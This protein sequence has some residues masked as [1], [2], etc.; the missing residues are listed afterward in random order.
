MN[1]IKES[2]S[3]VEINPVTETMGIT[4]FD[5]YLFEQRDRDPYRMGSFYFN[6]VENN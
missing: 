5:N 4:D 3:N 1:N 2:F 6:N